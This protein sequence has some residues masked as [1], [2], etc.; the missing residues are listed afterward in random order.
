M[1]ATQDPQEPISPEL[2]LSLR[3]VPHFGDAMAQ[4]L[5]DRHQKQLWRLSQAVEAGAEEAGIDG[6]AFLGRITEDERLADLFQHAMEAALRSGLESKRRALGRVLGQA[7]MGDSTQVDE[8]EVLL[9]ALV[10][11]EPPHVR[12]MTPIRPLVRGR[13][14]FP[15]R[16]RAADISVETGIQEY[17]VHSLLLQL[18]GWGMAEGEIDYFTLSA[19]HDMGRRP[20]SWEYETMYELTSLGCDVL[21]FLEPPSRN[22]TEN[23]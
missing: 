3:L 9:R 6:Q 21:S 8:H 17:L 11:L 4:Y 2:L 12:V 22:S 13:T 14:H 16:K 7:V 10:N 20:A 1:A 18:I 19:K 23:E 5:I 15:E